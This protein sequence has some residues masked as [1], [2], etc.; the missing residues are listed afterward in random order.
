MSTVAVKEVC[1]TRHARKRNKGAQRG[2][3]WML[4]GKGSFAS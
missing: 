3:K 1:C 2:G 4:E